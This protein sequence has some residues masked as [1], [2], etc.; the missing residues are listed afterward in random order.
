MRVSVGDV[1]GYHVGMQSKMSFRTRILFMTTGIFL[2]RLVNDDDFLQKVSHIVL[3]EVHERDTDIDFAMVVLKHILKKSP[4][5]LILMSATINTELFAHYFSKDSI[6]NIEKEEVYFQQELNIWK[7]NERRGQTVQ[8][9]EEWGKVYNVEGEEDPWLTNKPVEGNWGQHKEQRE[10][11]MPIKRRCDPAIVIY[12]NQHTYAV[13]V[14]YY[15]YVLEG[16]EDVLKIPRTDQIFDSFHNFNAASASLDEQVMRATALL[17]VHLIEVQNS[18]REDPGDK[19]TILVFMPGLFE[20]MQLHDMILF[21]GEKS[22]D[23]IVIPLHSSLGD[24]E[25]ERAFADPPANKRKV[26][27]ATNIAESSITIP[28]VYFVIDLCLTKEIH[29]D[30]INKNENLQLSWAS[31]AS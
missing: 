26:I 21:Q 9:K 24:E 18:F 4:I 5:K 2:Q 23:L 16:I 14:T 25:Q 20:I 15:E 30:P 3:D 17:I 19:K 6:E 31:K 27:L 7:N 8:A 22:K 10:D 1:V 12:L 11:M 13:K 29:Y 28:D